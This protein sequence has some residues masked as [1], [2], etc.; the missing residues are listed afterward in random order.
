MNFKT[1]TIFLLLFFLLLPTVS[2]G[3][4]INQ[5][6]DQQSCDNSP[7]NNTCEA[8]GAAC[9]SSGGQPSI[10]ER[11]AGGALLVCTRAVARDLSTKKP[12][13]PLV[14]IPGVSNP[15]ADFNAYIN[16]LYAISISVA[17]LLAVIKII[18]AGVKWMLSDAVSSISQAKSDIQ[19]ALIGLLI[20]IS[21]VLILNIINPKL[22]SFD[23]FLEPVG[24]QQNTARDQS[25][26]PEIKR[27]SS[28]FGG[29][30]YP[31]CANVRVLCTDAGGTILN[32][33]EVPLTL[34]VLDIVCSVPFQRE[35]S[36]APPA[37]PVITPDLSAAFN[38]E[39]GMP[40][41]PP[42]P[43]TPLD[44]CSG[45]INSCVD[46]DRLA[47]RNSDGISIT[48]SPKI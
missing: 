28:R 6:N 47:S 30:R 4:L 37:P 9:R 44:F 14:K 38:I 43:L 5:T 26:D 24:L 15:Q 22:T 40:S 11:E 36:P 35:L 33:L 18:I 48:C 17:A 25:R 20:V 2:F 31:S 41:F 39:C 1:F 32:E 19:G 3:Q 46:G 10:V 45:A 12:F 7:T 21:A 42:D 8:M 23:F 13:I 34:G 29:L 27:C 16:A